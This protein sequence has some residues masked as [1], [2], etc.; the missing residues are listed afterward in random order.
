MTLMEIVFWI[1]AISLAYGYF[2]Y[3]V[4]VSVLGALFPRPIRTAQVFPAMT[5][6]IAA[7]NEERYIAKKIENCLALIYPPELLDTL[8]ISD[9][10]T[11]QTSA[12]VQ[13]YAARYP[14]RVKLKTLPDRCGKAA[15][16]NLGASLA[17]GEILLLAD[18]RQ[19]F[20]RNVA[21]ALARNFADPTVGAASGELML[22]GDSGHGYL[23]NLGLY[24]NQEKALRKA[25]SRFG[26]TVVYTGAVSAIRRHLYARLPVDTLAEDL[27]MPL[28]V[29]AQGYRVVFEP[30][31]RASDH[32]SSVPRLE[33]SRKVRTIAGLLQTLVNMRK[34][35][36]S[37]S[38]G[39]WWQFLSHKVLTR[40]IAPYLLILILLSSAMLQ[41]PFYRVLF[42]VQ[43]VAY[44][45]GIAGLRARRPG[46]WRRIIAVPS[47]FLMLNFAAVMGTLRYLAGKRLDLWRS[48]SPKEASEG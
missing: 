12:I 18:A 30:E 16:L 21:Q 32:I 3:P 7:H 35:I 11:D 1:A 48:L 5:I 34:L 41:H 28:R 40:L 39:V 14:T 44:A 46:K 29:I 26:S 23:R 20:D 13:A 27:V 10:S 31:A 15:A 38:L 45:I 6:I 33:F 19:T 43:L 47:T 22:V 9:G 2:G 37:L 24:W 36:G 4:I 25:E 42:W 17:Q 8:I